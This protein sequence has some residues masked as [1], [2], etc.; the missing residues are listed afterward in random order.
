MRA[1]VSVAVV[2]SILINAGVFT[3]T[4]S[5]AG[6]RG[7]AQP[8]G[9]RETT[10]SAIPGV[11]AAGSAWVPAWQGADNADGLVGTDDGALLFAQE[12][13]NRVSR[14]DDSGRVSVA[15]ENTRGA[16]ALAIDRRGRVWAALRTCTDPG[17]KPEQ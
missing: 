10:V 16:G 8:G 17:G 3:Q 11:V 9:A 7:F 1:P 4:A 5:V 12:Q 15:F 14:L 6:Q 13:P 2:A